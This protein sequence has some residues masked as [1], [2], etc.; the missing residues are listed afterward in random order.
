MA[1]PGKKLLLAL[2][3]VAAVL[4]VAVI[5]VLIGL[6]QYV[7]GDMFRH[8]IEDQLGSTLGARVDLQPLAYSSGTLR[9][10]EFDAEG[11]D[12]TWFSRL[13]IEPIRADLSFGKVLQ[14]VWQIDRIEAESAGL[15]FDGPRRS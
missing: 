10:R 8:R 9:T 1:A 2:G 5:A 11:L 6:R 13:K 7:E 15:A 14:G 4:C 12:G 3:I